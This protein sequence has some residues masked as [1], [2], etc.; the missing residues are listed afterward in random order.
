MLGQKSLVVSK[1]SSPV[2]KSIKNSIQKD[3]NTAIS[4]IAKTLNI[5]DFYSAHV[6]NYCEVWPRLSFYAVK[7]KVHADA[8]RH[9]RAIS[10]RRLSPI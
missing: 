5:H 2:L 1:T 6:L 10:L 7:R 9:D 4:D 8:T 3:V